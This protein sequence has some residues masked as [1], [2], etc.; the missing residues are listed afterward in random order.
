VG[1][2]VSAA[3]PKGIA[4]VTLDTIVA[5]PENVRKK[6]DKAELKELADSIQTHGILQPLLVMGDYDDKGHLGPVVVIAG[7][8][9]HAAASQLNDP[10]RLI[11]VLIVPP[12]ASKDEIKTLQMVENLQRVDLNS[13]EE[14]E[15]FAKL[16]D[17][18]DDAKLKAVADRLGRKVSFIYQRAELTRFPAKLRKLVAAGDFPVSAALMFGKIRDPK[19]RDA[20]IAEHL[21]D[22]FDPRDS[23]DEQ[24]DRVKYAL[25]SHILNLADPG[26]NPENAELLPDVGS[27]TDCSKRSGNAPMLFVLGKGPKGDGDNL[28]TDKKCYRVKQDAE[29]AASVEAYAG[30]DG[31]AVFDGGVDQTEKQFMSY[32]MLKP[33]WIRL[34]QPCKDHPKE[35]KWSTVLGKDA[36]KL[37]RHIFR[38]PRANK[39]M[40]VVAAADAMKLCRARK[41]PWLKK[42]TGATQT[43]KSPAATQRDEAKLNLRIDD[44]IGKVLDSQAEGAVTT[45]PTRHAT[46]RFIGHK[47]IER[48]WAET[49]KNVAKRRGFEP[50]IHKYGDQDHK[51][52]ASP[53]HDYLDRKTLSEAELWG[54]LVELST[55]GE[56]TRTASS[57]LELGAEKLADVLR[58]DPKA[59]VT[60]EATAKAEKKLARKPRKKKTASKPE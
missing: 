49:G 41:D 43:G 53:M 38:D 44:A 5:A 17:A 14:A 36:K 2:K 8:R 13:M 1:E 12:G 6:Y 54:F 18:D 3:N 37:T 31:Y 25:E 59:A 28:C 56:L 34:T 22:G 50:K 58:V 11:P 21:D 30:K 32:G 33:K 46:M 26:F 60:Q 35:H 48:I 57:K 24:K 55:R 7:N 16:I 15:A 40:I 42:V 39:P 27:C 29:W 10:K 47:L 4:W 20:A 23:I 51:D 45:A 19:A 9:R 52:Y